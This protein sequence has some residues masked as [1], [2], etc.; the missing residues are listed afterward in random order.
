MRTSTRTLLVVTAAIEAAIGVALALSPSVPVSLL[1]GASL[2]SPGGLVIGRVAGAALL[3]LGLGCWLA[4]NDEQSRA[5]RGLIGAML[6]YNAA[7]VSVLVYA[8]IGLGLSGIGLWP[9]V[10]LHA[11][12][13][14]WCIACLRNKRVN[15]K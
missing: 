12:L 5:A 6:L 9:A 7:A 10:I 2:D 13:A 15:G 4:R 8:G 14:I 1:L 3:S 11:A